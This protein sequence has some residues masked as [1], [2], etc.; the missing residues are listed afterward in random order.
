LRI[1]ETKQLAH[2]NG[3]EIRAFTTGTV[4]CRPTRKQAE[5]YLRYVAIENED[6]G[7]VDRIARLARIGAGTSITPMLSKMARVRLAAA[8]GGILLVGAPDDVA[9]EIRRISEAG[10]DGLAFGMVTFL[11]ELPYFAQE[12]MPRLERCGLRKSLAASGSA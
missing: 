9:D 8:F 2:A 4:I 5:D 7:A 12:V 1:R 11:D 3:H 6:T 10:F